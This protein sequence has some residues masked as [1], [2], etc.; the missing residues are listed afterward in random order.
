MEQC[1][2]TSLDRIIER[3]QST[4]RAAQ[5]KQEFDF[6]TEEF[7]VNTET[8]LLVRSRLQVLGKMG[9]ATPCE[10]GTWDV[11][12][13]F[14]SV[15]KAMQQMADRQKT[16]FAHR[17]LV[18]DE[19]LPLVVTDTRNIK[20]LDG[21][22]LGHGEDE[23]GR[24][25]GRHYMLLEGTDAKIHLIYYAPALEEARS[26]GDLRTNSFVQLRKLLQNGRP[27]LKVT[28][29]GDAERLL[30]N[31]QFLRQELRRFADEGAALGEHAWDGWLGRYQARLSSALRPQALITP[32]GVER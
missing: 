19:R 28:S 21:R 4:D 5:A 32:V 31:D 12:S 3:A 23:N 24:N 18:S 13:D 2:V 30:N 25:L 1:R 16:L 26:R 20:A 11:R 22:V 15:L 8:G 6:R 7:P 14:L 9:L 10:A 29:M 27:V 17:A